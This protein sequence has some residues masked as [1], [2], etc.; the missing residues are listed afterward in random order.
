MYGIVNAVYSIALALLAIYDIHH[1]T[2]TYLSFNQ[3]MTM[4]YVWSQ[5]NRKRLVE[6]VK[7]YPILYV[8]MSK[9]KEMETRALRFK[10]WDEIGAKLKT[11]GI[12]IVTEGR[13]INS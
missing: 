3:P 7:K 4:A 13:W 10:L 9:A 11:T 1:S 8:T 6:F 2:R 12:F 5:E